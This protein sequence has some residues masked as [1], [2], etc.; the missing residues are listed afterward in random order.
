MTVQTDVLIV[1]GGIVGAGVAQAAAAAGYSV[2]LWEKGTLGGETSA[3]SSKLIHGGLRY[4]ESGQVSLV[5]SCLAQRKQLL[6]LAPDL[7]KAVPFYIPVYKDSRRGAMTI[8]AGLSL[9]AMLAELEPHGRFQRLPRAQWSTLEGLD[10]THLKHVFQYWDAITHDQRL[11]QAVAA[12][13]QALGADIC[14]G[15]SCESIYH[16][17]K[18]CQVTGLSENGQTREVRARMVINACGP[19]VNTLLDTVTPKLVGLPID[20]VQG[21]HLLLDLPPP[22]GVLYLESHL[23]ERVVFVIPWE[24]KTLLGTTETVLTGEPHNPQM[25]AEEQEY[26]LAIYQH[27]FPDWQTSQLIERILRRFCGVRVLPKANSSAFGRS[28]ETIVH[29]PG[30][31]PGIVSVYG[32]KLTEYRVTAEQVLEIVRRRLGE[33]VPV[34]DVNQLVLT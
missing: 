15:M 4:L 21:S 6:R 32:G 3:N 7:V 19:W 22:R 20:W 18:V 31:H 27:Y 16:G 23:D 2:T 33:R 9:Y 30:S 12:S 1:G 34:A 25:T 17:A 11:T 14:E 26:L 5:K 24:G 13:A 28:R 29:D 8:A 10:Q